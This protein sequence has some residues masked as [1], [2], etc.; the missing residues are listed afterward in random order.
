M[1]NN[2]KIQAFLSRFKSDE[3]EDNVFTPKNSANSLKIAKT[4]QPDERMSYSDTF[5]HIN[6]EINKNK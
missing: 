5:Q 1:N 6:N 2:E 3:S 4:I